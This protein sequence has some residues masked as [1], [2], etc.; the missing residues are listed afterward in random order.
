MPEVMLSQREAAERLHV[1]LRT[2]Y[3]Y[4]RDGRIKVARP[5]GKKKGGRVLVPERE[6]NRLLE[7]VQ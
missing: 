4:I 1:S 7:V 6:V 2:L 3:N 5:T